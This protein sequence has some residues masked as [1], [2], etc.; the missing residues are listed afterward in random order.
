MR[1]YPEATTTQYC[2][3]I[4]AQ[5]SLALRPADTHRLCE[6]DLGKDKGPLGVPGPTKNPPPF[7]R[8]YCREAAPYCARGCGVP[9]GQMRG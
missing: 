3:V 5:I 1:Q 9:S 6:D 7:C 2:L 8:Q 4:C